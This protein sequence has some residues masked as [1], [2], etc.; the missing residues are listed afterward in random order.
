MENFTFLEFH[1]FELGHTLQGRCSFGQCGALRSMFSLL[2][3]VS[4]A[5]LKHRGKHYSL[6]WSAV[7]NRKQISSQSLGFPES[8]FD[9][10]QKEVIVKSFFLAETNE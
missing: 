7:K 5:P 4:I 9:P 8:N 2:N 6:K 10:V 1:V 3:S